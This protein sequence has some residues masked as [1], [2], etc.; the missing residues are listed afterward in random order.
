MLEMRR[1]FFGPPDLDPVATAE[2]RAAIS[3]AFL[4]PELIAESEAAGLPLL[5]SDGQTEQAKVD[6]IIA[7]SENIVPILR[8]ALESIR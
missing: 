6:Q 1:G 5:P 8:A 2:L 3:A 7:A 4:D